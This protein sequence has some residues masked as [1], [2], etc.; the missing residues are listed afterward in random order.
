MEM[1]PNYIGESIIHIESLKPKSL[2]IDFKSNENIKSTLKRADGKIIIDVNED[3]INNKYN[4]LPIEYFIDKKFS[5]TDNRLFLKNDKG[6]RDG[7]RKLGMV[8]CLR[9]NWIEEMVYTWDLKL[10]QL[11]S[12]FIKCDIYLT[13]KVNELIPIEIFPEID[14]L[15]RSLIKFSPI[16]KINKNTFNQYCK[17]AIGSSRLIEWIGVL[18]IGQDE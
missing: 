13:D 15:S 7:L 9:N 17:T 12:E 18:D 8:T 1:S 14:F 6:L 4:V 2:T 10:K 16:T 3:I 5:R 11:N